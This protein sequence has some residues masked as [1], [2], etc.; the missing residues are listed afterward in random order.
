MSTITVHSITPIKGEIIATDDGAARLW[1]STTERNIHVA[2]DGS[3]VAVRRGRYW[4][5]TLDA[6][7]GLHVWGKET[8]IRAEVDLPRYVD[9]LQEMRDKAAAKAATMSDDELAKFLAED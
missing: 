1:R 9:P 2:P 5:Y 6:T 4:T 7:S 8:D 3:H